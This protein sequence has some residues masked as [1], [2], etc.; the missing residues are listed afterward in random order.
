MNPVAAESCQS[1]G[2]SFVNNFTISLDEALRTG[3]IVRGMELEEAEVVESEK[4]SQDLRGKM[5]R[6]GDQKIIQITRLL[7]EESYVRLRDILLEQ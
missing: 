1:C 5:L 3:A 7:P 2:A 6:S 4:I